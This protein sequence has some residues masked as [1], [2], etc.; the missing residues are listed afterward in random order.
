MDGNGA[1][2]RAHGVLRDAGSAAERFVDD[3]L[4][5]LLPAGLDWRHLVQRYPQAAVAVAAAAGFWIGRRKGGLVLAAVTSYVAAQFGDAIADL[6][7]GEQAGH[8]GG[9]GH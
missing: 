3:F 6:G 8:P 1:S 7:E 9:T 5:E 2:A 4:D